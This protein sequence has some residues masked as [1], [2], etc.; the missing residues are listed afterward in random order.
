M[1]APLLVA[2]KLIPSAL[3]REWLTPAHALDLAL[4]RGTICCL[5]GPQGGGKT[6]WL[7]ALAAVEPPAEG[8]LT[9]AGRYCSNL[10]YE[11]WRRMRPQIAYIGA[12]APL[13]SVLN[14]LAN[15]TLP[16][17]YHRI[18]STE[19]IR[20]K[21][22]AVL[23]RLGWQGPLDVLPAYLDEHQRRL[24]A[25][26][27]CLILDPH[28]LFI[29]EPFRMTDVAGWHHMGSVFVD[30]AH[31][32]K[33]ALVVVTHHLPFVRRHADRILFT[34]RAGVRDYAGWSA[35]AAAGDPAVH[36]F[37]HETGQAV[38]GAR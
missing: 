30:L 11:A 6:A 18:G 20:A 33:I 8:E 12:S 34:S 29:D 7:R 4:E 23:E 24:L 32:R 28:I 26:A 36:E 13:L 15:V 38:A 37:L 2:R 5:I 10:A 19:A 3:P 27:R 22:L 21:A 16:A 17:H 25:L 1:A 31:E 35:L 14:G 9:I